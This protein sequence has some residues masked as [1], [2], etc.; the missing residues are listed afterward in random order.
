MIE[1]P[2]TK[3]CSVGE[4]FM[5]I[6]KWFKFNRDHPGKTLEDF[7][8]YEQDVTT[9]EFIQW[10]TSFFK[11]GSRVFQIDSHTN[12]QKFSA[13]MEHIVAGRSLASISKEVN[14]P[15]D[16]V[17]RWCTKV[18]ELGAAA[19]EPVNAFRILSMNGGGSLTITSLIMMRRLLEE[20]PDSLENVNMIAGVSAGGINAL[21][22]ALTPRGRLSKTIELLIQFWSKA[23]L[24]T[25]AEVV[26]NGLSGNAPLWSREQYYEGLVELLRQVVKGTVLENKK[27]NEIMISDV[28]KIREN[29]IVVVASFA[30]KTKFFKNPFSLKS[31]LKPGIREHV[32]PYLKDKNDWP[33]VERLANELIEKEFQLQIIEWPVTT[34]GKQSAFKSY[35]GIIRKI[36]ETMKAINSKF[37]AG[38]SWGPAIH[39]AYGKTGLPYFRDQLPLFLGEINLM[40]NLPVLEVMMMTSAAPIAFPVFQGHLDGGIFAANPSPLAMG[41]ARMLLEKLLFQST[42]PIELLSIGLGFGSS[43]LNVPNPFMGWRQWLLD[44]E[45]PLVLI[46]VLL[47]GTYTSPMVELGVKLTDYYY[48]NSYSDL[49]R[50]FAS[51]VDP[52]LKELERI[53]NN[54]W[55]GDA[56]DWLENRGWKLKEIAF[57]SPDFPKKRS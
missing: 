22:L 18:L 55:I 41:L 38:F 19:L 51:S 43:Y 24:P 29:L 48:L 6:K 32:I 21:A 53:G 46:D 11:Y 36:N 37:K 3:Q 25:N 45:N 10:A 17:A 31:L 28:G 20:V 13:A 4:K 35:A 16:E 40:D 39:I 26:L 14:V 15:E 47:G 5:L 23:I 57:L 56:V 30:L 50:N 7:C 34:S 49:V 1:E 2:T 27:V 42:L 52:D 12:D 33:E 8:R 54:A 44:P 9:S